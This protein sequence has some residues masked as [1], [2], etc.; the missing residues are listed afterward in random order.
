VGAH[1]TSSQDSLKRKSKG[2]RSRCALISCTQHQKS[3]KIGIA[4]CQLGQHTVLTLAMLTAKD[5]FG[6]KQ[7]SLL[8]HTG[9][10]AKFSLTRFNCVQ[11]GSISLLLSKREQLWR[12]QCR[13]N[14]LLTFKKR[15]NENKYDLYVHVQ[16]CM[17]AGV[18]LLADYISLPCLSSHSRT[19]LVSVCITRGMLAK[20]KNEGRAK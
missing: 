13:V 7:L 12:V 15:I 8:L 17:R 18:A 2:C 5:Q 11:K 16:R 6:W 4:S 3:I 19:T 20:R 14:Q 1:C 9:L 10:L